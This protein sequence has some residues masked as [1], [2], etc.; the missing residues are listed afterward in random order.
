MITVVSLSGFDAS[1]M[2]LKLV[3]LTFAKLSIG[4]R[5]ER[6]LVVEAK[7]VGWNLQLDPLT[8]P[9]Q[10]RADVIDVARALA[11]AFKAVG[12]ERVGLG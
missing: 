4:G 1:A 12:P 6:L 3:A 5:G 11:P 2:F 7:K 10:A 8:L 9:E